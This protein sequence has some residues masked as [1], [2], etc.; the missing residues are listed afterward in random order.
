M[1]G[2]AGW[3]EVVLF[4]LGIG[5]LAMEIF[6]VPGFGVF[7]VSGIVLV[8]A[9]L[10][11]AG[12]SWSFDLMTNIEELTW[13][14]GQVLLAFAIVI[15]FGF[16]VA[17][18]LPSL[19]GFDSLVLGP[20]GSGTDEP[21]L[22]L[23]SSPASGGLV[24]GVSVGDN[25]VALTMLRPSGKARFENRVFDVI[26]DGPFIPAEAELEVIATSGNRIVVRQV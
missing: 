9:S 18:L 1:G 7:G 21:R 4:V 3:L 15:A 11:M 10:V 14:S 19:P 20:P 24:S 23:E 25:G 22:R 26:S 5:C 16:S 6:V 13:Q 17:R 12:H 8:L 2:T